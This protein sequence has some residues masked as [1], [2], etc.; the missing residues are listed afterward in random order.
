[1]EEA[2]KVNAD[3]TK[4]NE[5]KSKEIDSLRNARKNWSEKKELDDEIEQYKKELQTA[6]EGNESLCN[7]IQKLKTEKGISNKQ[8]IQFM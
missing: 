7:Q 6:Q 4:D 3:L 8:F 1:M 2:S 5:M